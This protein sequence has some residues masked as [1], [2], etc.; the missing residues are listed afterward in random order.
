MLRHGAAFDPRRPELI[1]DHLAAATVERVVEGIAAGDG[2]AGAPRALVPV[3]AV[4]HLKHAG[5]AIV[6][7]RPPG[8]RLT[9]L[10]IHALVGESEP[11]D[12]RLHRSLR[13]PEAD[14][15]EA[16]L[17]PEVGEDVEV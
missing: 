8:H 7:R 16:L 1:L 9:R 10:G 5:R 11:P 6:Q 4:F 13:Q 15:P 12:L 3:L 2:A 17:E 14:L